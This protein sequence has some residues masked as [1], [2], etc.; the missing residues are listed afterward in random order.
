ML[1]PKAMVS[2]NAPLQQRPVALDAWPDE[3]SAA[4]LIKRSLLFLQS[5]N[6]CDRAKP[7]SL[8]AKSTAEQVGVT[9]RQKAWILFARLDRVSFG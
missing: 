3:G 4:Y 2:A 9:Q 1:G 7:S 6:T 5:A 8:R